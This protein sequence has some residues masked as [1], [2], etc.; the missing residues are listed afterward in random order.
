MYGVT[1]HIEKLEQSSA[2]ELEKPQQGLRSA[3]L[4]ARAFV[5]LKQ[6]LQFL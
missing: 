4:F 6:K 3:S 2:E 1:K 5:L